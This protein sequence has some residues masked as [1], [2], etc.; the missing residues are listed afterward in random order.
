MAPSPSSDPQLEPEHI[1]LLLDIG[2]AAI[3]G[4]L[5][6][7]RTALPSL[8]DLP[9]AL[10]A[11]A[12]VFVTLHVAGELNGC[13][14]AID[15]DEPL[16]HAVARLSLSAAFSDPRLPPLGPADRDGLTIELSLLS[17]FTPLPAACVEDLVATVRPG[18]DGLLVRAGRRQGLFLPTVWEQLPEPQHFVDHLWSKAGL[19]RGTWPAGTE[20]FRFTTHHHARRHGAGRSPSAACGG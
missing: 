7:R 1:E 14:G 2:E 3:A 10:H 17:P 8:D 12:R 13:I 11:P 15:G 18:R 9:A 19:P 4:A 6:G 5:A 16:G 20:T